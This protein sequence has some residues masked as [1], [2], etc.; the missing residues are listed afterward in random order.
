MLALPVVQSR[1]YSLQDS[2]S[3]HPAWTVPRIRQ[4][5]TS[6]IMKTHRW[7]LFIYLFFATEG[8]KTDYLNQDIAMAWPTLPQESPLSQFSPCVLETISLL[9]CGDTSRPL[10]V[11]SAY[12][13]A[14]MQWLKWF[15]LK[16]MISKSL[17]GLGLFSC[18]RN[19]L[20]HL[21]S[22]V[23]KQHSFSSS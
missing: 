23:P 18:H 17:S 19:F 7:F 12:S 6:Y 14:S 11:P 8:L 16:H 3:T 15:H 21:K 5:P 1:D 10:S 22:H 20:W 2:F 9:V 4:F 13:I